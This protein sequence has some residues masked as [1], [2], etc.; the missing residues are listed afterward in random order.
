VARVLIAEDE[1]EL[2]QTLRDVL[3]AA[4]HEARTAAGG[5]AA[6]ALAREFAP[7]L[8]ISDWSLATPP[9]GMALIESLRAEL[10]GVRA[11]LMTGYPSARSRAWA[12]SDSALALLEKPFS[13]ADLRAAV[14]RVLELK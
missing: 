10:P 5:E 4:G 3:Q 13:L 14:A 12:A 2:A 8:V 6:L 9:D 11:I 1:L 7:E